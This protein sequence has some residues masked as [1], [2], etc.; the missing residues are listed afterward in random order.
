MNVLLLFDSNYASE[1][2]KFNAFY[3]L[4]MGIDAHM[5]GVW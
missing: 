1:Y 2:V 4:F 3:V 5:F